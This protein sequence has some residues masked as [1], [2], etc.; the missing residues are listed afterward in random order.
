MCKTFDA[1]A[2]GYGRGEAV[3]AIYVKRLSDALRD[4]DN[5]RAVIRSTSVNDD[6]RTNGM[7][8]PSPIAQEKLIRQAYRRAGI[9]DLSKTAMVEC[10]GTGTTVGDRNEARAVANCFGDKGMIIT[11][12]SVTFR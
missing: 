2:D 5:V 12:V 11:S 4:G 9:A 1:S 3:N 10:H 7:L 6:G 8:T